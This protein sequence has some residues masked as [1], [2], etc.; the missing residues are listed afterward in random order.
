MNDGFTR[1]LAAKK[2]VDDRALNKDIWQ[3]LQQEMP[4][5]PD[6]L[7]IGAGIGT[8]VERLVAEGMVRNGRYTAIDNQPTHIDIAR[9]PL[10]SGC[11]LSYP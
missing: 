10:N 3:R 1:Y 11:R 4:D 6:I 9:S 8:M 2:S 7:E 5:Q